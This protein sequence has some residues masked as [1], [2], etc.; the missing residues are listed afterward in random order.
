MESFLP[1]IGLTIKT[2]GQAFFNPFFWI[3][4][5]LVTLQY[6]RLIEQEAKIYG[7]SEVKREVFYQRILTSLGYGIVGG[8]G[9]S[10][11]FI[12]LGVTLTDIGIGYLWIVAILGLL[13]NMRFL[14]FSY[15]GGIVS[16][17]SLIFGWP[18]V[19][20]SSI[21]ALVAILHLVESML[22]RVSGD[23]DALPV[24]TRDKS[25]LLSGGFILQKL[26]PLPVVAMLVMAIST[27]D[28]TEDLIHMPNWWPLITPLIES[29]PGKELIFFLLPVAVGLG[30]GDLA[31]AHSPKER[32]KITSRDLFFYSVILLLLAVGS[33]F[34]P[35][36]LPLGAL[37]S[38]LGHELVI[39]K[40]LKMEK[41]S[42]PAYPLPKEGLLV[43]GVYPQSRAHR[44]GFTTG[45]ILLTFNGHPFHEPFGLRRLIYLEPEKKEIMTTT[46]KK[47]HLESSQDLE[48]LFF[49]APYGEEA[50]NLKDLK[51]KGFLENL[52]LMCYRKWKKRN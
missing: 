25:G 16:L 36:L 17:S 13:V 48:G 46:G 52:F 15:A 21:L 40:G 41:D 43:H 11:I 4:M 2:F 31:L 37:F 6:R 34:Y 1:L 10:F 32:V 47:I 33:S 5:M 28:L 23:Q 27:R 35:L 44:A 22:I 8:L 49:L 14:C 42:P 50:P 39:H 18:A 9:A 20:I 12:F 24:V 7:I 26:W 38:F 45:D 51:Q 19:N 3:V 30:Y 29:P